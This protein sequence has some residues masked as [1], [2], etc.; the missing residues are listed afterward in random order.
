MPIKMLELSVITITMQV[1]V[2]RHAF[3]LI[4][5]LSAKFGRYYRA[6]KKK[7]SLFVVVAHVKLSEPLSK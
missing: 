3:A 7:Q 5:P 1:N 4:L 6:F 2:I